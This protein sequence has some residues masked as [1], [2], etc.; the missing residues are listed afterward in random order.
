VNLSEEKVEEVVNSLDFGEGLI[1][2]VV[3]D[4]ESGQILMVAFMNPKSLSKTLETGKMHFWSRSR[5]ELWKKGEE[6]GNEQVVKRIRVDC[7]EDTLLF[8]VDPKGP[9]C[10]KGYWSCFYREI[11]E[12]GFSRIL[13][14]GFNPEEVYK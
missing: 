13:D 6:S 7:D 2:A 1:P 4:F 3:Q 12:D 10:H 11:D 8:D 9:A 14:K 5:E